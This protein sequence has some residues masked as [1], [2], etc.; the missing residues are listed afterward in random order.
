VVT[1]ARHSMNKQAARQ[2]MA[3]SDRL[4]ER[5]KKRCVG[6][7]DDEAVYFVGSGMGFHLAI[8]YSPGEFRRLSEPDHLRFK[9]QSRINGHH[10]ER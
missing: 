4:Y 9:L 2:Q 10:Y 1:H 8:E 6:S 5:A 7:L 3:P